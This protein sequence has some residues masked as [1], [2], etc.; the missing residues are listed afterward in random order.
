MLG[1]ESPLTDQ[2]GELPMSILVALAAAAVAAAPGAKAPKMAPAAQPVA[3]AYKAPRNAFGQPDF[4]GVWT[5][6]SLTSLERSPQF[7][8]LTISEAQARAVEERRA[9]ASAAANRPTD[10]NAGAPPKA[11][12]PGGTTSTGPRAGRW[13]SAASWVS[14]RRRGRRC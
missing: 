4:E 12:D 2:M 8:T 3:A 9:M 7:K 1:S 11:D 13:A 5:N 10:P 6:A 14:A